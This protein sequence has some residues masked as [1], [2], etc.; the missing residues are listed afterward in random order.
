MRKFAFVA[1][2]AVAV[3][4]F[5]FANSLSVPFFLDNGDSGVYP[6][7]GAAN[8]FIGLIN[9]SSV[10]LVIS[11]IYVSPDTSG[12]P[13]NR[14]PTNNTFL[15]PANASVAWRPGAI[16]PNSEPTGAGTPPDMTGARDLSGGGFPAPGQS[17]LAGSATI[18][19]QGTA[20][21]GASERAIKGRYA[22]N[23]TNS[24]AFAYF[25]GEGRP[26]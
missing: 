15:L 2:A 1:V 18:W 25:L 10:D 19:W 17:P 4:G 12:N 13:S 16:D 21:G 23:N 26:N 24:S 14:T 8:G 22:Q 9:T 7:Q 5:A 3:A 6:T 11:V 20:N